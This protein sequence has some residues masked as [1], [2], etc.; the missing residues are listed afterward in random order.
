MPSLLKKIRADLEM[1]GNPEKAKLLSRFFKTGKGEYGE[2]DVFLG[3]TVPE[4][5]RIATKYQDASFDDLHK[6]I[7]GR[8]HEHRLVALLILIGKYNKKD[9]SNRASCVDFYIEHTPYINNWDLIDLSA[10]KILGDFL[11][12]KDKSILYRLA[13]SK[14]LWERRIAIMATFAFIS[15]NRFEDALKIAG[16]LL[17]DRH[18]LIHKAVGWM[19][20]EI[21][22]KDQPAE[23]EFLRKHYKG[24]PRTML[25][26]AIERFDENKKKF[27][28]QKKT[29][30]S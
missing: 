26:Y 19:L 2:G 15:N 1:L 4:Q 3:I 7:T 8:I 9:V 21:G 20:R 10:K 17:Q 16:I 24:M 11:M 25:R 12:D 18:D 23:E 5:R 14:S 29:I 27:Y 30:R 22:K 6:L 13:H 28:M